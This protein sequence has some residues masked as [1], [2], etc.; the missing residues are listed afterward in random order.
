M[1]R[2]LFNS[3]GAAEDEFH[4]EEVA[5]PVISI[6]LNWLLLLSWEGRFKRLGKLVG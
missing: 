1:A 5:K 2:N 6:Y 4:F 3:S